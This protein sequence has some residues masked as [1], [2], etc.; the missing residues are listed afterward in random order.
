MQYIDPT[1]IIGVGLRHGMTGRVVYVLQR[2]YDQF[3]YVVWDAYISGHNIHCACDDFQEYGVGSGKLS[4]I[5]VDESF[6][7]DDF[8]F[9]EFM[10]VVCGDTS[11]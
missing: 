8:A 4:H 7:I 1:S 3:V 10:S 2:D 11:K 9:D 6:N 5:E